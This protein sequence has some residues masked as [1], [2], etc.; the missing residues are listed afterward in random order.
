[1][2]EIVIYTKTG[3]P[4]C[5]RAKDLLASKGVTWTE[6]DVI[7]EPERFS[8]MVQRAGGRTTA[9]QIFIGGRHVGGSDDLA[10]LEARGELDT[11]LGETKG[12]Q[13]SGRE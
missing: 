1:M 5:R 8:E 2:P 10:A 4:Y 3:C 11:L 7:A 6:I 9:P 13:A 12:R